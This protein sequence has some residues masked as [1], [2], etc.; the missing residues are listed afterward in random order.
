MLEVLPVR[1]KAEKRNL[2]LEI[3]EK[4][5]LLYSGRNLSWIVSF[6]YVKE[7]LVKKK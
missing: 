7:D 2:L 4:E 6:Y 5:Y 3:A 1:T